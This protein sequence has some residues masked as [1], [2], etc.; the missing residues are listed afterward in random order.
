M[1]QARVSLRAEVELGLLQVQQ[2]GTRAIADDATI[3]E[4]LIKAYS[5]SPGSLDPVELT[6]LMSHLADGQN[7]AFAA[8]NLWQFGAI[9]EDT[10]DRHAQ[11]HAGFMATAAMQAF[12]LG[13]AEVAYPDDFIAEIERRFPPPVDPSNFDPDRDPG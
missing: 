10:W 7:L 1:Q 6:R 3:A 5:Q 11:Y 9:S 12:W 8:Y 4:I 13:N 2:E